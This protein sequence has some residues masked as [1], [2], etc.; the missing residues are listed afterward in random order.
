[1]PRVMHGR[2][3]FGRNAYSKDIGEQH[4]QG[5]KT[6]MEGAESN[7]ATKTAKGAV[8]KLQADAN[9]TMRN[10]GR[11]AA[12]EMGAGVNKSNKTNQSTTKKRF[13]S[14]GEF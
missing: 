8:M 1:M 10:T 4:Y 5:Y 12:S 2:N 14:A 7:N 3:R 6:M 9:Q 13:P 11:I